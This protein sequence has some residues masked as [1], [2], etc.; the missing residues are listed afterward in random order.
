M[1]LATST[2]SR[3]NQRTVYLEDGIMN[4]NSVLSPDGKS[5]LMNAMEV[6]GTWEE[7]RV[8]PFDGG[9]K[10]R[11]VGPK[12]CSRMAWSPDG[13]WMYFSADTGSG[14]HI[15]RQRFPDGMPKQITSGTTEEEGVD[16]APDGRSFVTSVGTFQDTIWV[17]DSR[18][19]RQITSEAFS[20]QPAFSADG[21]KLYY[22]VRTAGGLLSAFGGL[23]VIDLDS[24]K[25]QRLLP[26]FKMWSYSISRDGKRVLF[27]AERKTGNSGVW[28]AALDGRSAPRQFT[29]DPAVAAYFGANGDIFYSLVEQAGFGV[30]HVNE[31]GS[32][33]RRMM[34]G[35]LNGVSPDGRYLA[36][37][38]PA[39][40]AETGGGTGATV[41]YPIDGGNPTPICV[42][43][44]RAAD[45]PPA[46]SWSPD[47]K[48][49]YISLVGGQ[50]VWAIPLSRGQSVPSLPMEI[51]SPEDMGK[52]P[53]AKLLPTSGEFPGPDPTL[54]AFPKFTSQRNIYRVS[55][56]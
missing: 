34:A 30:Y 19:D 46:V 48:L 23:W 44:N 40:G 13:K 4:H 36:V 41:I 53:G 50:K 45:A 11:R 22:L 43:G 6:D 29:S 1:A 27:A 17:H 14:S 37:S 55:V 49:F 16:V 52:L 20:F 2:E 10:A 15:W 54:Y 51:R 42:C 3:S 39:G 5:L 21:K 24:G 18:G 7:C 32:G 28:L 56:P 47:G 9:A 12:G 26:E 25:R 38:G 33:L 8:A 31:D 35:G